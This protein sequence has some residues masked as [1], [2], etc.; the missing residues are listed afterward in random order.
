MFSTFQALPGILRPMKFCDLLLFQT[1]VS[2]AALVHHVAGIDGR[3]GLS[4]KM[5]CCD[6]TSRGNNAMTH[7][8]P[9]LVVDTEWAWGTGGLLTG[10]GAATDD[11]GCVLSYFS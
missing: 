4:A 11:G 2:V 5:G 7:L 3:L 8:R 1:K 9:D 6:A 10:K